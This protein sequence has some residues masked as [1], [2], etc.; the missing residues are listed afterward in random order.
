MK[1][2]LIYGIN[3]IPPPLKLL[4]Y[5]FQWLLFNI[6]HIIP[7]A[8]ILSTILQLSTYET[9]FLIQRLL[10]FSGLATLLQVMLGHR[11]P[12]TE[13]P[14][15]VYWA[16]Y[17]TF[18]STS[19]MLGTPISD[20]RA[21][22]ELGLIAAGLIVMIIGFSGVVWR[23]LKFFTP[24][25]KGTLLTLIALTIS[26][27]AL[28]EALG[29]TSSSPSEELIATFSTIGMILISSMISLKIKG[30]LS[31]IS[32]LFSILFGIL[33]FG[34]SGR[35]KVESYDYPWINFPKPL[36]WGTPKFDLGIMLAC[37]IAAIIMIINVVASI[38]AMGNVCNEQPDKKRINRGIAF[39]GISQI[40]AGFL[41][42][43]GSVPLAGPS[44]IVAITRVATR[45][46]QALSG[47]IMISLSFF[48]K[49]G[50]LIASIPKP[51]G[52]A[53]TLIALSILYGIGLKN[54]EEISLS[55][56]EIFIIGIST[57]IGIGITNLPLQF[58]RN[59]PA[60]IS[61]VIGNGVIM[62]VLIA[63]ILEHIV[64]PKEKKE[65]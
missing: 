7:T 41:A 62:G 3:E 49:I 4:I 12:I 13:G 14:A 39:N 64:L 56:R 61:Y 25:I 30:F 43:T 53:S 35:I 8:F 28:S 37:I 52:M 24:V 2:E 10:F 46:T 57:T 42:T 33:V 50:I 59:I 11:Y 26:S 54:F 58:K 63:T 27:T 15:M 36:A 55:S 9:A 1:N 65:K 21:E 48:P 51:V 29:I 45:W 23:I 40:L 44:G 34:I 5:S 22:I 18:S 60:W 16:I 6:S 19:I 38:L 17:A 32:I 47:L 20:I 31:T